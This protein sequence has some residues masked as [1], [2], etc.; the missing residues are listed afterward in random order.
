MRATTPTAEVRISG[1]RTHHQLQ[2]ITPV[3]FSTINTKVNREAND[4]PCVTTSTS[5]FIF[6]IKY[7]FAC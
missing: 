6:L 1:D 3:S 5:L 4:G 7:T 2:L